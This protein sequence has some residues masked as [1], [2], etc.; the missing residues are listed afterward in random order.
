MDNFAKYVTKSRIIRFDTRFGTPKRGRRVFYKLS[1]DEEKRKKSNEADV[2]SAHKEAVMERISENAQN[3]QKS[4]K[5]KV[6]VFRKKTLVAVVLSLAFIGL[7]VGGG[8][9]LAA[10]TTASPSVKPIVVIDAGHGGIDNGVVGSSGLKESDFNLKMSL[11]LAEFLQNAGFCVV[12]TRTD[13]NG[14]YGDGDGNFKKA[15][16]AARKKIIVENAPDIVISIHANK[17]P[18]DAKR[19]GA[20]VFYDAMS[21]GGKALATGIQAGL[22]GLNS[23]YVGRSFAALAGD[24]FMLKCTKNPSVIV[25]CGFLS[26]AEDEKLLQ[27][28]DY[29]QKLAFAIYSGVVGFLSDGNA[30]A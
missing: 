13:E 15:D 27:D 17:Y 29:R 18:N 30:E 28:N 12:M 8:I 9:G 1:N 21:E 25:E 2:K 7:C 3:T 24:Y 16:M 6:M 11:D 4:G 14:L 19:R 5:I 26:N 10:A 22:N 23:D 20:Q